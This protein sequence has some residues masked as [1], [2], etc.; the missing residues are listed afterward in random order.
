VPSSS[1]LLSK[2]RSN[3]AQFPRSHSQV[4]LLTSSKVP[5]Q[6]TP[7]PSTPTTPQN[8][9]HR[10]NQNKSPPSSATTAVLMINKHQSKTF[11]SSSS[12]SSSSLPTISNHHHANKLTC[13]DKQYSN[14]T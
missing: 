9:Q 11:S 6:G 14:H 13:N 7:S 4:D 12:P 2:L 3:H 1:I 10:S 8:D 5:Q